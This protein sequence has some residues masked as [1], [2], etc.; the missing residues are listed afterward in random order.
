M[1]TLPKTDPPT[2]PTAS[3]PVVVGFHLA[4]AGRIHL[5]NRSACCFRERPLRDRSRLHEGPVSSSIQSLLGLEADREEGKRG[6][7][8]LPLRYLLVTIVT[9]RQGESVVVTWSAKEARRLSWAAGRKLVCKKLSSCKF[10]GP[11]EITVPTLHFQCLGCP[12]QPCALAQNDGSPSKN[13]IGALSESV[14]Q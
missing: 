10:M 3:A 6:P 9:D 7:E 4:I 1:A 13:Q 14:A 8:Q 5:E 12:Q 2:T 11:C